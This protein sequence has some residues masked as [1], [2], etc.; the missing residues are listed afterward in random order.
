[1]LYYAMRTGEVNSPRRCHPQGLGDVRN[2]QVPAEDVP[3]IVAEQPMLES[4]LNENHNF[5][6]IM[7][8]KQKAYSGR[9][10]LAPVDPAVAATL[11][12]IIYQARLFN[13]QARMNVPE[14]EVISEVLNL[15]RNVIDALAAGK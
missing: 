12:G 2:G 9:E 14:G 13:R 5:E 3:A 8:K 4:P 6:E 7:A 11:T 15:W 1:M 10:N